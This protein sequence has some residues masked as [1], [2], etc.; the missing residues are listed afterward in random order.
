[1]KTLSLEQWQGYAQLCLPEL[2]DILWL[3]LIINW[4]HTLAAV[5][6]WMK[7]LA[8]VL[9]LFCSVNFIFLETTTLYFWHFWIYMIKK[10]FFCAF[11]CSCVLL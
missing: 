7:S 9:G 5:I 3:I 10:N 4:G 2:L 1:M 6:H 8:K 11:V